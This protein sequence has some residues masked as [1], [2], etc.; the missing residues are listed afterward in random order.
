VLPATKQFDLV[1]G[2]DVHIVVRPPPALPTPTPTPFTGF[3]FDP[4]D[5]V[6][7]T[8]RIQGLP[9]VIAGSSA[10]AMPPH[11]PLVGVFLKPPSNDGELFMGSSSVL[12]EG[13]PQGYAAL[14]VL[15]CQDVGLP[16][17]RR[18]RK[19][20]KPASM[21]LPTSLVVTIP[22]STS[23]LIGG[24]PT[25]SMNGMAMKLLG[26]LAQRMRDTFRKAARG[27]KFDRKLKGASL[28]LNGLA[29]R[30]F[31]KLGLIKQGVLRNEVRRIL[32][33]VTGHPVDVATGKVFTDFVDLT[34][35][36]PLPF[37]IERVWY[38]SSGYSGPLGHGWHASFDMALAVDDV[39]GVRLG[40][41]RAVLFPRLRVGESH[42]HVAE[43]MTLSRS[44]DGYQLLD[45]ALRYDF[46]G[47]GALLRLARIEDR[48][49]ARVC[50][51]HEDGR[52][53][54]IVD[55]G[56]R[57]WTLR[58]EGASVVALEGSH[59]TREDQRVVHQ[60]WAYDAGNVVEASDALGHAQR[61]AYQDRLLVRETLKSG[62]SFHFTYDSQ[63][64]CV[65]TWG[66][67]GLYD[68]KL[69]YDPLF[70][71]TTVEN[72]LGHKTVYE[73][74]GAMVHRE[75]DAL[76]N[77]RRTE[78][79]EG[80]RVLASVDELGHRTSHT[81]DQRGNLL[82]SVLPDGATTTI[83]YEGELPVRAVDPNGGEWEWA[84]DACGREVMRRDPLG[85]EVKRSYGSQ[86][87][88]AID[89]TRLEHDARENWSV[90]TEANGART[91]FEH[92]L[93]GR[94][95]AIEDA[96]GARQS[97]T[98]DLRG[99][100]TEV[101]EPD[102]NVRTLAY[103]ADDNLV[104]AKDANSEV[105]F[106]YSG[107]SRLASRSEAGTSVHFRYDAEEQLT[108]VINEH[109]LAYRFELGPTGHVDVER[110]FD[111]LTRRYHRDRAGRVT[112]VDRPA[113]R[114]TRYEHDE[115]GRILDV[116]HYDG[117]KESY[118]YHPDGAL[119]SASNDDT[120]VD[121]ERDPLGRNVHEKQ[122]RGWVASEYDPHG[123]R[124][125]IH[126][127]MGVDQHIT[128]DPMGDPVAI[129]EL[130]SGFRASF[131]RD[132]MGAEL[133]R[134]VGN[135][136]SR[137]TRD[138]SGR[139]TTHL[140]ENEHQT[141]RAVG[142]QWSANDRLSALIDSARGPT[143]YLHDARGYLALAHYPDGETDVRIPDAVGNLYRS[144]SRDD[145]HYGAA[146]ALL[147]MRDEH[148]DTHFAY[149]SE[150]NLLSKREPTGATW[151][152]NWNAAGLL[153][154]VTRPDGTQVAFRYDALARRV[155]K[156][157]RGQTTHWLWDR[158]VPLHEW[159]E[160]DLQTLDARTASGAEL[161]AH[162]HRDRGTKKQPI[163][164][165]FEPES[166]TPCARI[167]RAHAQSILC[168]H[169]GT[170]VLLIDAAG[171][172]TWSGNLDT[173]GDLHDLD[174]PRH[175]ISFRWPGQY[176]DAEAGLYYNRFRY[177]APETGAYVSQDP[178]RIAGG[179]ALF[180][181]VHDP[182]TWLDPCGLSRRPWLLTTE[183]TSA[184]RVVGKRT[185]Y[186]HRSTKLWWSPDTAGHGGSAFKVYNEVPGGDLVW[187]RDA[188]LF[189]DFIDP[190]RKHK[191]PTGKRVC[192]G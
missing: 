178:I 162:L 166:F 91:R 125:R 116:E 62:L 102:G 124:V 17:P 23:V 7:A 192:G 16:V 57:R 146:G 38:S 28:Y 35:P 32:C 109:G 76:G 5:A 167:H 126:S 33:T 12:T 78:F 152:Y 183:Q 122:D 182:L 34:L 70:Q 58:Y 97:R 115:L 149:D 104:H 36:G 144:E 73:H 19:L 50:F 13:E 133:E 123:A 39:I 77:E 150:G 127:S 142:Y 100:A 48:D 64:R 155:S 169:L 63:E 99:R 132:P 153:R 174:G 188:D 139:P 59:P 129:E 185:Y 108:S 90:V 131:E 171:Q 1:L 86:G 135:V 160:G 45:G 11:I 165:L 25:I 81:Y 159:V 113:A 24:T 65:R 157:Y 168:D 134:R 56:G 61:F 21:Y 179:L 75:V 151:H 170:P 173:Y 130:Q 72:S 89:R 101:R 138:R 66:D 187:Y 175:T 53:R 103:D 118:R 117:S 47:S 119:R 93:L 20:G 184:R 14:P 6:G 3:F 55:S 190:D 84:Y 82:S 111:G 2:L 4:M 137:W 161:E 52:L 148:G 31:D 180:S 15:T 147:R 67:G 121:F 96:R 177:Y 8:V 154:E 26:P 189:G 145:R 128:R 106:T 158:D 42:F 140:I 80:Y 87:L 164:W 10:V 92:D 95:I 88:V 83:A 105:R 51:L 85:H 120:N 18:L 46:M 114:W 143:R 68:H 69:S 22:S 136:R 44:L 60:R 71:R 191:G 186:E 41:G 79:G 94:V 54:T 181:Y 163:T 9:R 107:M 156:T 74:D 141:L 110:G 176:E 29:D 40:D 43:R 27:A 49:G 98:L 37:A 30:V 172:R 112:R